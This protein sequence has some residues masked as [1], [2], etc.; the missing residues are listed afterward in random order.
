MCKPAVTPRH[1]LCTRGRCP[2]HVSEHG[3]SS[4]GG[5]AAWGPEGRGAE[6]A[7]EKPAFL[8]ALKPE[9]SQAE[10]SRTQAPREPV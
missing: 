4:V 3:W 10:E 2:E 6:G 9:A 8:L 7:Q 5:R 1:P